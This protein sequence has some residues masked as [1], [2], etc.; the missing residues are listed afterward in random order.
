VPE[1]GH[2][3][4]NGA[5]VGWAERSGVFF[6]GGRIEAQILWAG[7]ILRTRDVPAPEVRCGLAQV[8]R[9]LAHASLRLTHV[10]FAPEAARPL[11]LA[12]AR[13]QNEGDAPA[14]LDYTEMWEVGT[15]SY[16]TGAGGAER[17]TPAGT[18]ALVDV[19]F[20]VRSRAPEKPP[21]EGLALDVTLAVPPRATRTLEFAYALP[22]PG[23]APAALV[24]AWRGDAKRELERTVQVW[25]QR[26]AGAGDAVA[27]YRQRVIDRA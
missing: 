12:I 3:L 17:D 6:G 2:P 7:A 4:A 21:A 23:E 16:R 9:G 22:E 25:A 19:A 24:R 15:G 5:C 26:L 1:A 10:V 14:V 27:A 20:A 18:R 13:V 11:L 8:R